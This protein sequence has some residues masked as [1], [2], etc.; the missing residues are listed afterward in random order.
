MHL[1][2]NMADI[3]NTHLQS[4]EIKKESINHLGLPYSMWKEHSCLFKIHI[5]HTHLSVILFH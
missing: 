3:L 5:I 1:Y 2:D 4:K